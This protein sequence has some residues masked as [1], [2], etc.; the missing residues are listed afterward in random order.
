LT[1]RSNPLK[2]V[3]LILQ[4]IALLKSLN[5][6]QGIHHAALPGEKGVALAAKLDLQALLGRAY[7]KGVAAGTGHLGIGIELGVNLFLHVI[8]QR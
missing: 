1:N 5:A 3:Y 4:L 2:D 6:P 7:G 8:S